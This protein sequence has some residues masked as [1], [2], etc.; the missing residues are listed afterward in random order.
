MISA[1]F[2]FRWCELVVFDDD[3]VIEI[4]FWRRKKPHYWCRSVGV[5][6]RLESACE[7]IAVLAIKN[8]R[9]RQEHEFKSGG[10]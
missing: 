9:E 1:D 6:D 3:G 8:E 5:S 4:K 7:H 2:K 10:W